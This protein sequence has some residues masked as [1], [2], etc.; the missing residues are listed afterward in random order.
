MDLILSSI[1]IAYVL[2][3]Y[4][5]KA[6]HPID[7]QSIDQRPRWKTLADLEQGKEGSRKNGSGI[8]QDGSEV[9]LRSTETE[10]EE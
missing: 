8:E 9:H 2:S 1:F 3:R 6:R 7:L 10:R 5:T 4:N